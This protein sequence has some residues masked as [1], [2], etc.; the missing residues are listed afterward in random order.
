MPSQ[1]A[2]DLGVP[3]RLT[4]TAANTLASADYVT[5][6]TIVILFQPFGAATTVDVTRNLGRVIVKRVFRLSGR[7]V[8]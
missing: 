3:H 8:A 2:K 6:I 1:R 4:G 7:T 5:P